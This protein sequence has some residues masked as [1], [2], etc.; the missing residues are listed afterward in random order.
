MLKERSGLGWV[1]EGKW[2]NARKIIFKVNA[3]GKA[4]FYCFAFSIS[5]V[6]NENTEDQ[7]SQY[8]MTV[9]FRIIGERKIGEEYVIHF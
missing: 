4:S 9:A 6:R 2:R 3:K 8:L 1:K 5:R 7:R